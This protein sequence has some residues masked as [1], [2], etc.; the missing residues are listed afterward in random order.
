MKLIF[1]LLPAC[2]HTSP[3]FI[4]RIDVLET[5]FLLVEFVLDV[6]LFSEEL[7]IA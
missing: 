3:V 4:N 1:V 6:G 2:I 5:L 7:F